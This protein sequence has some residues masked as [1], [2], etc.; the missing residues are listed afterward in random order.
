[1]GQPVGRFEVMG[2]DAAKLQ[3]YYADLF[4]WKI[5]VVPGAA[6]SYGLV[7]GAGIGGGI[8]GSADTPKHV[9]S[10]SMCPTSRRRC[11]SREP[12]RVTRRGPRPGAGRSDHRAV[13]RP[14]R[15]HGGRDPNRVETHPAH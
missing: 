9:P 5:N 4:N 10:T 2:T 14:R 13:Q 15:T 7:D 3:N 8:G 1:M 12:R 11:R 6:V